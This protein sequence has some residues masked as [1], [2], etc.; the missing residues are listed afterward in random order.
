MT[1]PR[2]FLIAPLPTPDPTLLPLSER[3]VHHIASV[4]RMREGEEIVAV[5]FGG[6]VWAMRLFAVSP[7]GIVAGRV[8]RLPHSAEP[9]VVLVQGV[10][11]GD[12]ADEVV[13][14]AV[15]VG[16]AEVV[17]VLTAR[18]VVKLD[19]EKRAERGARLRR[20]AE[21]AAKQSQRTFV[22]YVSD[23]V[24]LRDAVGVLAG[25]DTVLVAYEDASAAPGI[26][27][28]LADAHAHETSRVAI[29]VGPEGGFTA[30]EIALLGEFGATMVSLGETIL[31]TETAGVVATA[32]VV[33]EL[34]GLGN[35][36]R[37]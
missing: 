20:V 16:V 21:A 37:G 17:P 11:K 14:G 3:D 10:G 4:L 5:E 30:D 18:S 2:F 25:C 19:A 1:R 12:K 23:P 32:L 29:V 9:H 27:Q 36:R 8:E 13:Q 22:P 33:H 15:E 24:P 28:A 6:E 34:G 31:R 7:E 26:R 35:N